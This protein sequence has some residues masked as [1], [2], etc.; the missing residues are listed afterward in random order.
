MRIARPRYH[1]SR[2]QLGRLSLNALFHTHALRHGKDLRERD[3]SRPRYHNS[4]RL[5]GRLTPDALLHANASG[6]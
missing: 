1:N 3:T 2:W 6:D 4:R 5:L